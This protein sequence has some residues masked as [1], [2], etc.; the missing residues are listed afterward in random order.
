MDPVLRNQNTEDT[1]SA[2]PNC[3]LLFWGKVTTTTKKQK[4][5]NDRDIR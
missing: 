1:A 5:L 2:C 3:I 4:K